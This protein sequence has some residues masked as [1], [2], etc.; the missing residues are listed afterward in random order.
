[1]PETRQET[2]SRID[3]FMP[4]YDFSAAYEIRIN[5]PRSVVYEC[6]LRCDFNELWLSRIL[7]TLRTGKLPCDSMPGDLPQRLQGTGFI[8]LG[9]IPSEEIVI[10]VAGRFWRPDGER[11]MDLTAA[12]FA[13]FSRAGY[14]KATWN[15]KLRS[16]SPETETEP[17]TKTETTVLST[18]TRVQ[19]FGGSARWKFRLYWSLIAPFS[20]LIRKAILKQVKTKAESRF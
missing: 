7:M 5:A 18:E 3:E 15:F 13:D 10:G 14:A 1:M 17:E 9:E 2:G 6:V 19:C 11:C 4:D 16:E 8:I 12:N 20:G